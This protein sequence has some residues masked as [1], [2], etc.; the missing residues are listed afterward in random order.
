MLKLYFKKKVYKLVL[1][2]LI[3]IMTIL[4]MKNM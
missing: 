3:C 1:M 2:S 4:T